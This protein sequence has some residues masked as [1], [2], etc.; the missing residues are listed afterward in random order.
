MGKFVGVFLKACPTLRDG[1]EA[2]ADGSSE[3][4]MRNAVIESDGPSGLIARHRLIEDLPYFLTADRD[5]A[6]RYLID[7]L[8]EDDD[9]S[10]VLWRAAANGLGSRRYCKSSAI[11]DGEGNGQQT[12]AKNATKSGFQPRR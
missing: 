10:V 9:E 8:R 6:H 4:V 1:T 12:W 5:W 3:R 2:F 7:P 11:H